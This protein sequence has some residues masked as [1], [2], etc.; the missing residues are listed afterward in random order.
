MEARVSDAGSNGASARSGVFKGVSFV[1]L[2]GVLGTLIAAYIQNL[3]AYHDKVTALAKDDMAAAAQVFT[4]ASTALSGPL[5]LQERLISGYFAA[6]NQK[7][8]TDDTA[9]VTKSTRAING[10]YEEA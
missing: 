10:P 3:S 8:D 1:G 7:A 9:Y 6:V 2:L 5:S 4:D